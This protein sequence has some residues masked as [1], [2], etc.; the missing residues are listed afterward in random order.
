M[1]RR[2]AWQVLCF[3]GRLLWTIIYIL[4]TIFTALVLGGLRGA[5]RSRIS[6]R[7]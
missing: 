2:Q 6:N 5:G 7:D 1:T 4:F 3:I